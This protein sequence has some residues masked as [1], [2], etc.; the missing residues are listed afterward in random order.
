MSTSAVSLPARGALWAAAARILVP[1]LW[2]GLVIGISF[3]EAPLKFTAPGITLQLGLGI[4]RRVFLAMNCVEVLFFIL[5]LAGCIKRGIDKAFGW[6]VAAAG[7]LLLVKT[8]VIR[9]GL[10]RRTDAVLAGNFEGGSLWH[11]AYIGAEGLLAAV[12]VLLLVLAVRRWVR[13][14]RNES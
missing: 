14:P 5:L 1:A 3:I 11:Y 12:L 7:F 13:V 2:L 6:A 8:A 4:G 9:P 10:S